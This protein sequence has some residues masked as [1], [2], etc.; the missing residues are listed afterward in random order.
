MG[1]YMLELETYKESD[2]IESEKKKNR[3]NMLKY[4]YSYVKRS[5]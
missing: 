3:K 1:V 4:F 5:C 2:N